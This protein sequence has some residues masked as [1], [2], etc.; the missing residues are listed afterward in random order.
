[1]SEQN[2]GLKCFLATEAMLAY[3]RVKLTSASGEYVEYADQ[4]DAEIGITQHA[5]A[6]GGEVTVALIHG[7]RTFKC[8]ASEAM[9]VGATIYGAADGKVS[10]TNSGVGAIG[11]A[12]QAASGAGSIIE[13]RMLNGGATIF[14]AGEAHVYEALNGGLPFIVTAVCVAAGAEDEVVIASFP[15]KALVL[16]AWMIARGTDVANVTLKQAT[17]AF[18]AATA[19]GATDNAV[20]DFTTIIAAYDE[21]A[22]TAAVIATFSAAG[23]VDVFLLC[24]PIA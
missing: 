17:N 6:A 16:R 2:D 1:M 18:T 5:V 15:R 9:A 8:L 13:C 24:V 14:G 21:I 11:V 12:L 10:D 23:A 4:T 22:A 20:V 19:K 7:G 3:C